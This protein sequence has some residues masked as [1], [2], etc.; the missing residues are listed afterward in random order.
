MEGFSLSISFLFLLR[1]PFS[2]SPSCF[3]LAIEASLREEEQGEGRGQIS[4]DD[5]P[6]LICRRLDVMLRGTLVALFSLPPLRLRPAAT[7]R[8]A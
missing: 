4:L 7:L 8:P 1:R 6:T 3:P 5:W 2:P